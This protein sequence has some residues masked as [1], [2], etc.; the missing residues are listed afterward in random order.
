[1][2]TTNSSAWTSSFLY[3]QTFLSLSSTGPQKA[4]FGTIALV[5]GGN[6]RLQVVVLGTA[7]ENTISQINV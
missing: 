7:I 3:W 6:S 2:E 4:C 1:M 5:G